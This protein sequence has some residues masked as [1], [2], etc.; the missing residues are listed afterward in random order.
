MIIIH[1]LHANVDDGGCKA[2]A[3]NTYYK[4]HTAL[5]KQSILSVLKILII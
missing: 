3:V 2:C 4:D 5:N 1:N